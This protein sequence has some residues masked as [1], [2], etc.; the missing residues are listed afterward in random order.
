MH[1]HNWLHYSTPYRKPQVPTLSIFTQTASSLT[2]GFSRLH[3]CTEF[4]RCLPH[5]ASVPL[6][7]H[8]PTTRR[9]PPFT[10]IHRA[11]HPPVRIPLGQAAPVI[12]LRP[13]RQRGV[14]V[15][16]A[17]L[18]LGHPVR[19]MHRRKAEAHQRRG[20]PLPTQRLARRGKR[21]LS[22][23]RAARTAA[24]RL[25][26]PPPRRRP[27]ASPRPAHAPPPGRWWHRPPSPRSAARPRC[28]PA[29]GCETPGASP[30]C[31][32]AASAPRRSPGARAATSA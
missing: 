22:A 9:T 29:P 15:R 14:L 11:H 8:F 25:P 19:G 5:L 26:P 31:Q 12:S 1:S 20:R 17:P 16:L 32:N 2:T 18:E 27:P 13:Q 10:Q 30:P 6:L 28:T 23:A 21:R 4:I 7:H 24:G 3:G